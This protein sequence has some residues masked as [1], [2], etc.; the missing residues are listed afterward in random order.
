MGIVVPGA[1]WRELFRGK[2]P[3][4]EKKAEQKKGDISNEVR[5]GTFLKSF[6]TFRLSVLTLLSTRVTLPAYTLFFPVLHI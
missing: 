6:D 5:K 2:P 1:S 4:K 3:T